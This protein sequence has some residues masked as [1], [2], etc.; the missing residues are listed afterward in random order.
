M[1]SGGIRIDGDRAETLIRSLDTLVV[2][3]RLLDGYEVAVNRYDRFPLPTFPW[4]KRDPHEV[5]CMRWIV[6]I[7]ADAVTHDIVYYIILNIDHDDNT[8]RS[9]DIL[10]LTPMGLGYYDFLNHHFVVPQ[11]TPPLIDFLDGI[12][13]RGLNE[14]L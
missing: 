12:V 14:R 4:R 1:G 6:I 13:T 3:T 11:D 5:S 10:E 9:V 8:L 2:V 7:I